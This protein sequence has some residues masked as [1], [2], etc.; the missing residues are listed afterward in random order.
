LLNLCVNVRDTIS[1]GGW[2]TI[3]TE[4]RVLS[5]NE[6]AV[7]QDS[8]TFRSRLLLVSRHIEPQ[9][10]T[11]QRGQQWREC[12]RRATNLGVESYQRETAIERV[13]NPG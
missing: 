8:L 11:V 6:E 13:K 7:L 9:M 5:A 4:E 1:E 2:L 12:A 3:S 10:A